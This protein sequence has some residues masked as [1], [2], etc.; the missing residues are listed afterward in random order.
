[1]VLMLKVNHYYHSLKKININ[2]NGEAIKQIRV[3]ETN[4]ILYIAEPTKRWSDINEQGVVI[5]GKEAFK[6]IS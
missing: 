1:M 3:L 5:E 6:L 4:G 2:E